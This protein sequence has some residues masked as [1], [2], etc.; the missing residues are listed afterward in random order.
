MNKTIIL[1][2]ILTT[3]L[4]SS[5][6]D[7]YKVA[8]DRYIDCLNDF[9]SQYDSCVKGEDCE[10]IEELYNNDMDEHDETCRERFLWI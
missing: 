7:S 5:C 10:D 4:L 3:I 9:K 1:I 8:R 6:D 2:I